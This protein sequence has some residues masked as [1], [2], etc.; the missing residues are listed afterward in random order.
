ML[1]YEFSQVVW[2]NE[3]FNSNMERGVQVGYTFVLEVEDYKKA[4]G[5][6]AGLPGL[7]C[8]LYGDQGYQACSAW[9]STPAW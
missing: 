7:L 3:R 6:E 5:K 2:V 4:S 1:S 8:M 9:G